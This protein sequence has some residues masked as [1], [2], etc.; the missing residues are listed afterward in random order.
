MNKILITMLVLLAS[1]TINPNVEVLVDNLDVP[2]AIAFFNDNSFLFTERN[3]G[4][5]YHYQDGD[6][7]IIGSV[8]SNWIDE[9]GLLGIAIDSGFEHNKYVYVYYT[10]KGGEKTLNRVSRYVYKNKLQNEM[11][12]IDAIPGAMYHDGGRLEFGPDNLLYITTGD[13][14]EPS[15]AQDLNSLAGKIL[16]INPDGTIPADNPFPN[17]PVYSYGHRNPQGIAWHKGLMMATEHGPKMN[18]EINAIKTGKNYG[19]PLVECTAHE[20]YEAPIRCF[21]DWTL[22]PAA[23]TFDDKGNLYV[24]GLRGAQIRKFEIKDGK[25]VSEEIFLE[26]LGRMREVKYHDGYL[27]ITTSNR[28]GRGIPRIG[29]DKILRIKV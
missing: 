19:W 22:A 17:S 13:A 26:D 20:G 18:D 15:L 5:V 12:L 8:S 29:D 2:W 25:I 1:C 28:D 27:Y 24:A 14:T 4:N 16:R 6:V 9:G 11:I 3:T 23:A 21:P 7:K 10:Y